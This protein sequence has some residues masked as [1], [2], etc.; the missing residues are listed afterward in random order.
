MIS[1][2]LPLLGV[3]AALGIGSVQLDIWS[4]ALV[5]EMRDERVCGVCVMYAGCYRYV[6]VELWL[7]HRLQACTTCGV[8]TRW[9]NKTN[10]PATL[11]LRSIPPQMHSFDDTQNPRQRM[12]IICPMFAVL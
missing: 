2:S 1:E 6:P 12:M 5:D 10:L 9:K 8:Q 3:V 7:I 4:F 11:F